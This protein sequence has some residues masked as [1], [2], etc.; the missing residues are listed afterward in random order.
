MWACEEKILK[1]ERIQKVDKVEVRNNIYPCAEAASITSDFTFIPLYFQ[2][3]V[4]YLIFIQ[5]L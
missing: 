1:L 3:E 4:F 2:R 5:L